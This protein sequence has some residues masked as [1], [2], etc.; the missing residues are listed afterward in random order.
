MKRYTKDEVT[1]ILIDINNK[2][3]G[4]N[5]RV[6]NE[7]GI[8]SRRPIR[9]HFGSIS[10]AIKE[11]NL[12]SLKKATPSRKGLP[13]TGYTKE[14][15]LIIIK[16][17]ESKYGYFSKGLIDVNGPEYGKINHKVITRIWGSF[18]ELYR[19]E[20]IRQKEPTK[21]KII[22][23]N[24]YYL[25][26]FTSYCKKYKIEGISSSSVRKIC[27]EIGFSSK[28]ITDRFGSIEAFAKEANL[29]YCPKE[30]INEKIVISIVSKL[31]DEK[32]IMQYRTDLVRMSRAMPIDAY[33]PRSNICLEYNGEQHYMYVEKFH[34]NR[35]SFQKQIHRDKVKH[36]L[37]Q[38]AGMKLLVVKY[39]DTEDDIKNK[40]QKL[41]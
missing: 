19:I 33:F 25:N 4:I 8:I 28:T 29:L 34:K 37:I 13:K 18:S 14:S 9:T 6:I 15:A 38:N 5:D 16:D 21:G 11:L 35:D 24:E 39:S 41:I 36:S 26:L 22:K 31:L 3:G 23:P 1:E 32:P 7:S 30:Y 12:K 20:G 17:I 27:S 40:L 10:N 2:N